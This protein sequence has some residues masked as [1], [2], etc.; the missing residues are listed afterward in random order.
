M[1][2]TPGIHLGPYEI[3]S[4]L[5][6][7]GMGEV[8]KAK[9]TRLDRLVAVK[10]LP[11]HLTENADALARFEREAKA[12]AALNH[13]NILGLFDIGKQDGMVFAV[14][15]LLEGESLHERLRQGPL[16]PRK[17]IE[18]AVQMAHG[19]AAAHDK[20]VVHRDLKSDNLW[21]TKDGRLKIL[22]FGLA[23]QVV[24]PKH[25]SQSFLPTQAISAD[26]AQRTQ[27]GMIL[28]TI[29][30]MSPEQVRGE[31][32]DARGDI[33]SFGAVLFEMLTGRKAFA[34]DTAADTMVA[35]LKEDP[36]DLENTSRPLSPGLL[37]V[38]HHCL[39]KDPAHRFQDAHDLAF[40]LENLSPGSDSAAPFATPFAPQ[41]QKTSRK[42]AALVALMVVSAGLA[43]WALHGG[44]DSAAPVAVRAVTYSGHDTSP[45]VSPDGQTLAF[46]SDRDGKY[47]IWLKQLHGGDERALTSGTDNFSRFSPDG[48]AILFTRTLG[49]STALYR[50]SLLGS[51]P[52]KI[53]EDATHG[54]WSPDGQQIAFV[55]IRTEASTP[56]STLFTIPAGGG[57][58]REITRF[59][60]EFAGFPRW[61]PDGR[62]IAL[63]TPSA[64][65]AGGVL[66]KVFV[67]DV[68]K[69]SFQV[70]RPPTSF[71]SLS[72]AAWV[73]D[74][75][76]IYLQ[77]ESATGQGVSVSSARAFR[78][79]VRSQAIQPLFWAAGSG[80]T[81]DL[82]PDGRIVFDGMSGRQN[83]REYD[84]TAKTAPRWLTRGSINDRQPVFSSDG[85]WVTFSS[86]RSGN[87]DLWAVSTHTG[88]VR[89][90][91]DDPAEDWDPGYSADGK[92]LLWNSNRSGNFEIWASNPDGTGAHQVTRDGEDAE[93]P[94][95]TRDGAWVVYA[96][97]NRKHPGMWK[98]H[99]DGSG[100][101]I[102]VPNGTVVLPEVSPDGAYAL[103]STNALNSTVIQV[104]R[105]E[106]GMKVP[107]EIRL[108]GRRQSITVPGRARW[109]PDGK[110]IIFTGRD[111]KGLYGVFIQEFIPGQDTTA[112]RRPLAGFDP[113]WITESLGLS[114]NGK[115]LVLSESER[116][117]SIIIADGLKGLERKGATR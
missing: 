22:D 10:V 2:L 30:Y 63:N 15:E 45:A 46:T 65:A 3:L 57:A 115:S 73:N 77:S 62:W 34:R 112:S 17:A 51:E 35:I 56:V 116:V 104:V 114:P 94:T 48:S 1:P 102:L 68:K 13:P 24:I 44:N 96:T 72:C 52:R 20:G 90:I 55:R 74:K 80:S 9:D 91:T 117:F 98:I 7:G 87:L 50:T 21:I 27:E 93:N 75:E 103:F 38:L 67:V 28:G 33:F 19:L 78:Q 84:L 37:R 89:S 16:P 42:W 60:G 11:E 76:I 29:G 100:A 92:T 49:Q 54:D 81:L 86:N 70:L 85:D 109:T 110:R 108:E 40:A 41:N 95:Q 14:M 8:W 36:P 6:A 18:L 5:G 32:V 31:N 12:V 61:S 59:Q 58:E 83:L 106:D 69:G 97:G 99:P 43:G 88:V 111:A 47:C 66:R 71:G 23:K 113:D 25:G 64:I 53:V 101:Q 26:P 39:E 105:V 82:L 107:F 79:N 4:P